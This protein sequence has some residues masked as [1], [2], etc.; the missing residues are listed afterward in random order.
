[1]GHDEVKMMKSFSLPKSL[2]WR[3]ISRITVVVFLF[4]LLGIGAAPNYL[5]GK[6]PWKE[7]PQVANLKQIRQLE[8]TGLEIPGWKTLNQKTETLGGHKWSIQ[9]IGQDSSEPVRLMLRP[10]SDRRSQPEVEWV[11]I[12]EFEHWQSDSYT[13][14]QFTVERSLLNPS[15][16]GTTAKIATD[17]EVEARFFRAWNPQQTFAVLQWYAWYGGGH[18]APSRWF[19]VDQRAQLRRERVPWI[20]VCLQ[21]PIEPLGDLKTALPTARS[22]GQKV[23]AAL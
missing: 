18:P 23:Q 9:E 21:I 8:K 12:D 15:S 6:W 7:P 11:D 13:R 2:S 4:V 20:A 16:E 14:L 17:T 19:F 5:S 3:M 1:M 22:L 10:L